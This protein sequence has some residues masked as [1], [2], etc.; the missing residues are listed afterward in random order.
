[1]YCNEL[2]HHGILG[3]KWGKRNGPPYP[4][5]GG[6][7]SKEEKQKIYS[8]RKLSPHNIYNKKH[9]DEV[10]EADKETLSTLSFDKNRTKNVDMFYATYKPLDKHQYN[11]LLNKPIKVDGSRMLKLRID[12][13]TKENMKIA[14]EDSAANIFKKLYNSDRDFYNFVTDES[15]MMHYFEKDRLKYHGYK[16][17]KKT[18]EK[19]KDSNYIPSEKELQTVYR[20]FNFVLPYTGQEYGTIK[21]IKGTK[22]VENQRSKFFKIAKDQGYGAILDTNDAIYGGYKASNPVIVFDMDNIIPDT[23]YRTTPSSK[24]FSSAVFTGRKA[25][26]I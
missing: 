14:S 2:Y 6:D 22:D 21:D 17:A 16:E 1:M 10:L 15:R 7:Y 18:L 3:Q 13:K 12:N 8:A 20:L 19:F 25:L 9:F 4:L 24:A 23:I 5:G 26:G 11:A